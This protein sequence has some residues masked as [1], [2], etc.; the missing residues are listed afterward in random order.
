MTSISPS[1]TPL[2]GD[3]IALPASARP[4][5]PA[6]P[7]GQT[8][9]APE[10][11]A[12]APE[13][14]LPPRAPDRSSAG[15]SAAARQVAETPLPRQESAAPERRWREFGTRETGFQSPRP[16][17]PLRS[18]AQ[19]PTEVMEQISLLR[20]QGAAPDP[21]G[22]P[23]RNDPTPVPAPAILVSPS[24]SPLDRTADKGAG[25]VMPGMA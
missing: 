25:T 11:P 24:G 15:S 20:Q 16:A 4:V 22:V 1:Q 9:G 18:F 13:T 3:P 5:Q 8:A 19:I 7:A 2:R 21:R 10:R 14:A 12:T 23:G 17:P 6:G